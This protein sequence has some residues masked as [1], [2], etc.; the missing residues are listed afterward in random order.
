MVEGI[1]VEGDCI[2]KVCAKLN[3][4]PKWQAMSFLEA[5]GSLR[6]DGDTFTFDDLV[7]LIG[8]YI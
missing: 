4:Y 3:A 6:K 7:I 2:A 5:L 8:G 1:K